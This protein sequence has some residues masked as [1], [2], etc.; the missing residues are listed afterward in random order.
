MRKKKVSCTVLYNLTGPDEFEQYREIDPA[1]LPFTPEYPIDVNTALEE[2][3]A[4][5]RALETEGF[6]VRLHNLE[7]NW[8]Q[9]QQLIQSSDPD[10]IFNMVELFNGNPQLEAAITGLFELCGIPYTGSTPFTLALCQRK[11]LTKHI[12]TNQG[13]STPHFRILRTS[14]VP[15]RHGLRYP[16]IVKPTREDASLGVEPA[17]VVYDYAQLCERA[18]AVFER[19]KQPVLVE[20]FIEGLELHV[21]IL[22]NDQPEVLPILEYDFSELPE[23]HPPIITYDVKWNPLNLAY[24]QV[25][26]QCPADLPAAVA[27]KV[28]KLAILAYQATYCRDYARVDVRLSKDEKP[29]VLEVNPNPDLT[30]GVSFMEAAEKAGLTF[31]QTL[32]KIVEFALARG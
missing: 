9:F 28:K 26:V 7:D 13:I 4:V 3:E 1:T 23:D 19:F 27:R 32:R 22:G 15:R 2:Y 24:H 6:D 18:A 31:Q 16:I 11:G 5:V 20:E 30:E 10:V 21:A 25:H 17:S 14:K 12:L 8:T 29:Y